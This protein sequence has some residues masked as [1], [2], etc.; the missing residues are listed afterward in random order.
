MVTTSSMTAEEF[1]QL[2]D[3]YWRF[4]LIRGEVLRMSPAGGRHGRLTSAIVGPL[5]NHGDGIVYLA[6]TGYLLARD[7]DVVLAP[8]A[9]FVRDER[10]PTGDAEIGFLELAPDIVLE[11]ISPNDRASDVMAKVS[12]Y[13]RAGVE[14]LWVVDPERRTL[15]VYRPNMRPAILTDGDELEA[16]D[17]IPEFRIQVTDIF[18][19][20]GN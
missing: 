13:L 11:V 3:D 4:E 7:P 15:T 9:A 8:D 10:I 2:H 14:L 19:Y 18:E 5:I 16:G 1:A 20:P 6:D 12:E 17:L